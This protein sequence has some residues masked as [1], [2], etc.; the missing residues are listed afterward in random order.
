MAAPLGAEEIKKPTK[1]RVGGVMAL[2]DDPRA[3]RVASV[4]ELMVLAEAQ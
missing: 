3:W 1:R 4:E 2:R